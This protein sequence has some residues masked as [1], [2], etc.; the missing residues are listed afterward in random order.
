MTRRI[1]LSLAMIAL[2]IA[3]VTS[4]TAAYFSDTAKVSNNT[5]AMGTVSVKG[6]SEGKS[7]IWQL[8]LTF[9]NMVP[10]QA[11]VSNLFAIKQSGTI[12]VDFYVGLKVT[13]DQGVR[14]KLEYAILETDSTGAPK[15]WWVTEWD[16]MNNLLS[17]WKDIGNNIG[18]SEWHYYKLY[19]YPDPDME[20]TYQGKTDVMQL[21]VYAVQSGYG[22]PTTRP[23]DY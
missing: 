21:I 11:R 19:I 5:F 7:D 23:Q 10:G 17:S 6:E 13:N 14:N 2:T 22:V 16:S 1:I 4:A 8:P 18:P 3:G 20:N 9:N 12:P 15:K